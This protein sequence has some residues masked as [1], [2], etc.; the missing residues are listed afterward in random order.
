MRRSQIVNVEMEIEG[1]GF[2]FDVAEHEL[3]VAQVATI[4]EQAGGKGVPE[5]M[6]TARPT[7]QGAL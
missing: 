2:E 5:H 1:G 6:A 7:G 4:G 3:D